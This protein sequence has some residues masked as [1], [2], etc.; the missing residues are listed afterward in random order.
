MAVGQLGSV[1]AGG[2]RPIREDW[3]RKVLD[4]LPAAIY[5]TDAAGR[6]TYYNSAAV[7]IAGRRP[8]LGVD[9]WCVTWR[10]Y[11]PDGTPMPHDQCPMAVALKENRPIRGVDAI[12]ERP[13]GTR[14]AFVP[15]PTPLHDARGA[16]IGAVNMLVDITDRKAAESTRAHLAAIVSSSDDAIISKDL[17]GTV[18]SWNNGAE[19]IFG[20]RAEEIVGR[21]ITLLIPPERLSEEGTILS[22]LRRGERIEHFETVRRRKDGHEI[23]VSLTISPVL[24]DTGR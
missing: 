2:K 3:C 19:V 8:E 1:A 16:L 11:W 7:E 13:D 23:D 21:S 14:V 12:L 24:D 4:G 5:T 6:I 20:Y 18:R 9:S 17:E 15:Y 10:L 22:R